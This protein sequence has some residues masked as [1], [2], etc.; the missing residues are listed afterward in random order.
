MVIIAHWLST[1]RNA[2]CVYI[3][4]EGGIEEGSYHELRHRENG[5]CREMVE[6]QSL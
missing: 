6:M 5:Q 4:D 1:V 2:D 3:P